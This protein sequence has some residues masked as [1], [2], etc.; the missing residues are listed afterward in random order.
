ML[1]YGPSSMDRP[2]VKIALNLLL[3]FLIAYTY[4]TPMQPCQEGKHCIIGG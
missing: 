3:F 1:F 2:D 4:K